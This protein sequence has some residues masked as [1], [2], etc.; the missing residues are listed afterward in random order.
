MAEHIGEFFAVTKTSIYRVIEIEEG[1]VAALK[2]ALK[3]DSK[4]PVG[5]DLC[6]GTG[7][8]IAICDVLQAYMPEKY[9]ILHQL[10]GFERKL[11]SVNTRFWGDHSG[12]I[13]ALFKTQ[14]EAEECFKLDDAKPCDAR[15]WN[16]TKEV[17]S[18]IGDDHPS[19]YISRDLTLKLLAA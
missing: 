18:A 7:S 11:E 2:I 4:I 15:W 17:L 16:K 9:G 3:G 12:S 14:S 1:E 13:I 5:R 19:F 10:T 8:M 6:E